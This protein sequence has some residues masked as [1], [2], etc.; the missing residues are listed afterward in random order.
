M[1]RMENPGYYR[2]GPALLRLDPVVP[3]ALLAC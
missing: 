3:G 2:L 1:V